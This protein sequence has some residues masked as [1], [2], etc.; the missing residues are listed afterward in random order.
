[1]LSTWSLILS[2]ELICGEQNS[3]DDVSG[4][5]LFLFN[6]ITIEIGNQVCDTLM[7]SADFQ[8]VF[9]E[10]VRHCY[11]V[12]ALLMFFTAELAVTMLVSILSKT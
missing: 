10:A 3:N 9:V 6:L 8:N 11:Y 7:L 4:T 1:M 12:M 5:A 2:D